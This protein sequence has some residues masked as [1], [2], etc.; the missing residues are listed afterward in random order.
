M[1]RDLTTKLNSV[2]LKMATYAQRLDAVEAAQADFTAKL[3]ALQART[4]ITPATGATY[5][6]AAAP[7]IV[8]ASVNDVVRELNLRAAKRG[9]IIISGLR[10]SPAGTDTAT[11]TDLLRTEL[12]IN[13]S[14]TH[15][16]R[17]GKPADDATRPRRLLVTVSS[18]VDSTAAIRSAKKLRSSTDAYVRD[19]VYINADLT[20]EQRTQD[21]NLRCELKRRRAAGETNLVIRDGAVTIKKT[22]AAAPT[23]VTQAAAPVAVATN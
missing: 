18:D 22:R 17:L 4:I 6:A 9:N 23:A 14:V 11:V 19:N 10:S 16:S 13:A 3:A 8:P 7:A 5:A 2:E 1:V 21:Y 15:C 20:P 12:N